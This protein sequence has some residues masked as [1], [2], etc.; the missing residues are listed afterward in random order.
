MR[1]HILSCFAIFAFIASFTQAGPLAD[2]AL[3]REWIVTCKLT[4][5]AQAFETAFGGKCSGLKQCKSAIDQH[6]PHCS[7]CFKEL[8]DPKSLEIIDGVETLICTDEE[9]IQSLG[10]QLFCRV[11]WYSGGQCVRKGNIPICDCSKTS[12]PDCSTNDTD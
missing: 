6:F 2:L 3:S 11:N 10:C 12:H 9:Q 1:K 4:S 5:C 7:L 8:T